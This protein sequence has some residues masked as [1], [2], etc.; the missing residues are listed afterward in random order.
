MMREIHQPLALNLFFAVQSTKKTAPKSADAAQQTDYSR[1]RASRIPALKMTSRYRVTCSA[2]PGIA[3]R[4]SPQ[5]PV[6]CRT[7][8]TSSYAEQVIAWNRFGIRFYV[9][10]EQMRMLS[11]SGEESTEELLKQC[12]EQCSCVVK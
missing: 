9:E 6:S 10:A 11:V 2:S 3:V 4:S 8:V 5:C 12:R 7:S 1:D